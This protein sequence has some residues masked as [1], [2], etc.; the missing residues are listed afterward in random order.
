MARRRGGPSPRGVHHPGRRRMVSN[1]C[2][3]DDGE[4]G[5]GASMDFGLSEQQLAFR[6]LLRTFAQRSIRPVAREWEHSGRYPTEI[7]D[8]MKAMGL[9]GMLV[10]KEY[11]GIEIDAVSYSIVFEEISKA[12][13]GAAGVLGTHTMAT[14]LL[15]TDGT[16]DQKSR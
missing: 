16:D 10:P 12:W 6:D 15:A 5:G 4:R 8:E 3:C 1:L 14:R 13:M 2:S 9:F 11:G 7:V